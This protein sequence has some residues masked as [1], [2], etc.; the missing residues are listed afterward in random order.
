[1]DNIS[2]VMEGMYC[3]PLVDRSQMHEGNRI[4]QGLLLVLE[5][6]LLRQGHSVHGTESGV[7]FSQYKKEQEKLSVSA[8]NTKQKYP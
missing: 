1:M 6:I 8:Q 3:T 4:K 7:S 5:R 2:M